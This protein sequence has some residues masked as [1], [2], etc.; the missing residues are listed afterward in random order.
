MLTSLPSSLKTSIYLNMLPHSLLRRLLLSALAIS[1]VIPASLAQADGEL[2]RAASYLQVSFSKQSAANKDWAAIGL[3]EAGVSVNLTD[4][5]LDNLLATERHTLALAAQGLDRSQSISMIES[6]FRNDQ[7]GDPTL[8]N[9]D[10]F[11]TL[12]AANTDQGWLENHSGVFQ[13]I[14]SSQRADGSF[15]FSRHSDS[16]ADMTAAAI[17]ALELASDKPSAAI[18]QA[19]AFL[20][21]AQNNDGGFG[22]MPGQSSN[23]ATSSW[24]MIAQV[25]LGQSSSRV[26]DYITVQQQ[27]GGYWLEGSSANYLDTAYATMAL[28]GQKLPFI[29]KAPANSPAPTTN[30]T[31][32]T[33]PK[34]TATAPTTTKT[35]APT[36]AT[37]N[38]PATQPVVRKI[39]R[40]RIIRRVTITTVTTTTVTC[41]AWASASATGSGSTAS[42]SASCH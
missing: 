9:D 35:A 16:D 28:S 41:S 1:L 21:S 10:I 7:F 8:I 31:R 26:R 22:V 36:P 5:P 4:A 40:R 42:A 32:S 30:P 11:G 6:S 23:I 17:W 34:P 12:A 14:L 20:A 3:G 39:I 19:S 15:G 18:S 37:K 13:T 33:S 24:A 38:S 2:S 27:S 25:S 29:K